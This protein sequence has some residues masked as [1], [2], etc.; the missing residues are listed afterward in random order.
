MFKNFISSFI[1]LVT[2]R[3]DDDVIARGILKLKTNE[4]LKTTIDD[5]IKEDKFF[6]LRKMMESV[7]NSFLLLI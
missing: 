4:K 5:I 1:A 2:G 7:S 6:K 3:I